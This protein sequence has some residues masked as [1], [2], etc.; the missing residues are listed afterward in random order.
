MNHEKIPD[1]TA[2][3]A[4]YNVD[5]QRRLEKLHDVVVGEAVTLWQ[6][7]N[8]IGDSKWNYKSKKRPIKVVIL[9]VYDN[10]VRCLLPAGYCESYTWWSFDRMRNRKDD[11]N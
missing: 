1:P 7:K 10:Y 8:E 11:E 9:G 5:K 6:S 4:I 2:D 3:Y